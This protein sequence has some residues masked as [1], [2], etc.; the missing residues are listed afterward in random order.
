MSQLLLRWFRKENSRGLVPTNT[1]IKNTLF[2][3]CAP[4]YTD[5]IILITY[6]YNVT[7]PW[8]K[9]YL[10]TFLIFL[11]EL[12]IVDIKIKYKQYI[13]YKTMMQY[14][15]SKHIGEEIVS[16]KCIWICT[17]IKSNVI[18]STLLINYKETVSRYFLTP[19]FSWFWPIWTPY[20]YAM[21]FRYGFN[22]AKILALHIL[23]DSAESLMTPRS[24]W[25]HGFLYANSNT[26]AKSLTP[27][28]VTHMH[29]GDF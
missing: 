12:H 14:Q 4:T 22:F 15:A 5:I 10:R 6:L 17:A 2:Q 20:S 16:L 25:H 8:I 1:L 26:S 7:S 27:R 3:H 21:Y 19:L 28:S 23:I 11:K 29:G 9:I 18:R 13:W 24:Y